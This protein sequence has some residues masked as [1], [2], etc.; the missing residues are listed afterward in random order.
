M[1]LDQVLYEAVK[2]HVGLGVLRTPDRLRNMVFRSHSDP[3]GPRYV[4]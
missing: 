2:A 3:P 4:G 1:S